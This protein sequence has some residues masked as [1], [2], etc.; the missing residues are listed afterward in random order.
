MR[1][2]RNALISRALPALLTNFRLI[3]TMSASDILS[4]I[5]DRRR[6]DV[7]SASST[8]GARAALLDRIASR[9]ASPPLDLV[10][11]LHG[12][13]G[14]VVAAE[15]KRASPSKGALAPDDAS[16]GAAAGAYAAGGARVVSVLTEPHWFRGSLDDLEAARAAVDAV[17]GGARR[18]ALLRK[19]FI[20]DDFQL[21]EARAYGADTALL[22]VAVLPTVDVLAPL[23]A[24]SRALGMEP[25]VEV[26]DE[27]E[28]AVAVAA[29]AR[30]IGVN[31][32]NLR[33]FVVDLG[34]TARVIAAAAALPGPP[35]AL[36]SLSGIRDAA[37][38]RALAADAVA[39]AGPRGLS[40]LRGFLVGEA[41][42]RGGGALVRD[43]LAAGVAAAA[44]STT[45][46]TAPPPAFD[47]SRGV[48]ATGAG[49]LVKI[50]GLCD[51]P[52]ALHAARSGADAV[53][54]IFVEGSPRCVAADVARAIAADVCAYREQSAAAALAAAV[55]TP[56]SPRAGGA[57]GGDFARLRAVT[58]LL[59][60][61]AT[62]ARPLVFFVVRNAAREAAEAAAAAAGADVL[63]LHGVERAEDWVGCR[64]PIVKALG[65]GG[66]GGVTALAQAAVSWSAVAVALLVDTDGGGTGEAFDVRARL[67]EFS[68]ALSCSAAAGDAGVEGALPVLLAGGL[69]AGNV[70]ASLDAADRARAEAPAR[71]AWAS[72]W[73]VDVSSGVESA[74]KR[75][76]DAARVSAFITAARER[77]GLA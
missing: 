11:L 13:D 68:D 34:T 6:A 42:M 23:I 66:A 3:A 53:G 48:A 19:E 60:A 70:G 5:V 51:A 46:T 65:V 4:T 47:W 8:P 45:T 30:A 16:A 37:D 54:M 75:V 15:F 74:T 52:A 57:A 39:A 31:N 9:Y 32:R 44:A 22:I 1:C 50:C 40:I 63:Q 17:S 21:L 10:A 14:F 20:F 25:L 58:G 72:V 62:R 24:A 64:F 36:L 2:D 18:V 41:L 76:K 35:L 7:S 67:D 69:H 28:L 49:L 26:I 55:G 27:A 59:R 61:A 38:V 29:G 12:A 73:G 77:G 33:T 43:L 71:V 56:P